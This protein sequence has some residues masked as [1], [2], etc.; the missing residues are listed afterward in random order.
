MKKLI[1]KFMA[2]MII[3]LGI[4]LMQ[5]CYP[6]NDLT[7]ENTDIVVT[8]Y[9]DSADFNTLSTYYLSDSV[10]FLDDEESPDPIDDSDVITNQI[11]KNMADAGYTRITEE[12][13]VAPDV[14]ILTGVFSETTVSVGWYYPWY[15]YGGGWWYWGAERSTDYWGGYY[16]YYPSYGGMPYYTSYTTGTLVFDMM[17]PDDYDI[18]GNDTLVRV[19][20]NAAAQG[21]LSS[22]SSDTRI[23]NSIDQAFLQSPQIKTNH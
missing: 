23:K 22:G 11:A 9:N 20:W 13:P 10:Y 7:Y 5:G 14:V 16:P 3:P 21:V 18:I 12:S 19:Y 6:N 4:T 2:I 1:L 8:F 17:N 15:G